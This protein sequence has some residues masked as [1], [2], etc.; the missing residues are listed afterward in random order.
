MTAE[1]REETVTCFSR[2]L[3][4]PALSWGERRHAG[5]KPSPRP[6]RTT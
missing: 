6:A 5:P 4:W 3:R 1:I 2:P